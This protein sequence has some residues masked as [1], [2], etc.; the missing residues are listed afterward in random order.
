MTE[1]GITS[2]SRAGAKV[3]TTMKVTYSVLAG[4]NILFLS[5]IYV[6]GAGLADAGAVDLVGA[7]KLFALVAFWTIGN[8]GV[9]LFARAELRERA[10]Q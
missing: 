9:A 10:G 6:V 2:T 3:S 4:F 7:S 8:I 1:T 5:G